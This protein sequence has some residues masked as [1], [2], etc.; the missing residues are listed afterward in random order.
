MDTRIAATIT[1][2][3]AD[4]TDADLDTLREEIENAAA[5]YKGSVTVDSHSYETN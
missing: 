4:L 1:I 5:A 2:T 3:V